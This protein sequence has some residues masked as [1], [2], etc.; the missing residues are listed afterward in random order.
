MP[1]ATTPIRSASAGRESAAGGGL[2]RYSLCLYV[3]GA[4]PNSVRALSNVR[5]LC[6]RHLAGRHELEVVDIVADPSRAREGQVI[7]APMLVRNLP[8]PVR[9]FIGDMSHT[10]QLLT[11][12]GL[13]AAV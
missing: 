3:T 13:S 8:L 1:R 5:T 6:E 4:T 9:R 11:G 2:P 10:E 12:L 7:A